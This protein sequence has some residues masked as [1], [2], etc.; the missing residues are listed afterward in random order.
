MLHNEMQLKIQ[1]YAVLNTWAQKMKLT[2]VKTQINEND[3]AN[4][5]GYAAERDIKAALVPHLK[6]EVEKLNRRAKKLGT[7]EIKLF[8]SEPFYKEIKDEI[9]DTVEIT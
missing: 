4:D 9:K 2:Q 8:I 3:D 6:N 5:A 7:P 1:W